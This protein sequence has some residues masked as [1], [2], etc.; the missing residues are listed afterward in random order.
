MI[1]G[2]LMDNPKMW[3]DRNAN[4]IKSCGV[5]ICKDVINVPSGDGALFVYTSEDTTKQL[6]VPVGEDGVFYVRTLGGDWTAV[7]G[8]DIS[9]LKEDLVDI[10][11]KTTVSGSTVE[12]VG[13]ADVSNPLTAI[14]VD[15][16]AVQAGS[17]EASPTNVRPISGWTG[18]TVS[19]GA[20]SGTAEST[21][22]VDWTSSAGTIYGGTLDVTTGVLTVNKAMYTVTGDEEEWIISTENAQLNKNVLEGRVAGTSSIQG[23]CSIATTNATTGRIDGNVR[24]NSSAGNFLTC[25]S[26]RDST[27]WGQSFTDVDT[28]KSWLAT[29]YANGTPIQV[30]YNLATPLTYQLEPTNLSA[31]AK[32]YVWADIGNVSVEYVN[33]TKGYI[34]NAIA[35]GDATVEVKIGTLA[36]LTTTAK[37][38]TV[39]AINEVNA[40]NTALNEDL[41]AISGCTRIDWTDGGYVD[42]SGDTIDVTTHTNSS[43]WRY[44]VLD[45][46]EGDYFT[47]NNKGATAQRAWA[48]V[49]ASGNRLSYAS[50]SFIGN[51]TLITAPTNAVKMV[52]NDQKSNNSKDSYTGK[53]TVVLN[54]EVDDMASDMY[55]Y[56]SQYAIDADTM[57]VGSLQ[58]EGTIARQYTG[59]LVTDYLEVTP[60]TA[61]LTYPST[62]TIDGEAVTTKVRIVGFTSKSAN[63]AVSIRD[64][65]STHSQFP[66]ADTIKYVR[67][68][69]AIV[70]GSTTVDGLDYY[71]DGELIVTLPSTLSKP[72]WEDISECIERPST[73]GTVGQVLLSSG[74]NG[75]TEWGNIGDIAVTPYEYKLLFNS[76]P[77]LSTLDWHTI[78]NSY[79]ALFAGSENFDAYFFFTD[80][81]LIP[82]QLTLDSPYLKQYEAVCNQYVNTLEKMYNSTAADFIVCGGDWTNSPTT[83]ERICGELGYIKGFMEAKFHDYYLVVGNHDT[84]YN[85]ANGTAIVHTA[86]NNLW[87]GGEN[88]YYSFNGRTSKFYVLDTWTETTAHYATEYFW[89][90]LK[91]L[92]EKL[93]ADDPTHATIFMHIIR[94]S[95]T[96]T[97]ASEK[98]GAMLEAYNAHTTITLENVSIP[99][100]PI[101]LDFIGTT[102]H[103]DAV[104]GGHEHLD[105]VETIGGVPFIVT[106]SFGAGVTQPTFDMVFA[107][108]ST[109]KI[110]LIRVGN[111]ESRTVNM[112]Q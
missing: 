21:V 53:T 37:T 10:A 15:I 95:A 1:I 40:A 81:H 25:V 16:N 89:N 98:L 47:L 44:T 78:M 60:G 18:A 28:W 88:A 71:T 93:I 29:L 5:Y 36:N 102:G 83:E 7:S 90:Q 108:Y 103:V 19:A 79:S 62:H 69:Y 96:V 109:N 52:L 54:D 55:D 27:I 33:D 63:S 65:Y 67:I 50:A 76:M 30:C 106:E 13:L 32:R 12:L 56:I 74:A 34:D 101:T 70:D 110:T 46:A 43:Y 104:M 11:I 49:D 57:T 38:D 111:G 91:W 14:T 80:P 51:N 85:S 77:Y 39:S 31:L 112:A 64:G 4:N 8:S 58:P 3:T 2:K 66:I 73:V 59:T 26:I 22:S 75:A 84:N 17:G 23:I 42:A 6:F 45:C 41:N 99:N 97:R 92:G 24:A 9:T 20:V 94:L 72:K 105:A 68:S 82:T 100:D 48:F 86:I 61:Y 107:D 35:A 87:Y